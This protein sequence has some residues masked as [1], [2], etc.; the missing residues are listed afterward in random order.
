MCCVKVRTTTTKPGMHGTTELVSTSVSSD[1]SILL[2]PEEGVCG[3][4][5]RTVANRIYGGSKTTI[6]EFPW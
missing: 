4:P 2:N 3:R 6:G 1:P 5:F